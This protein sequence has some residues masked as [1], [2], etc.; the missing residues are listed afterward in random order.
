MDRIVATF[1]LIGV[2]CF[3][4]LALTQERPTVQNRFSEKAGAFSAH[5]TGITHIR[6]DFYN[7]FGFGLDLD[8]YFGESF[9]VELRGLL[10]KSSLSS[11]ALDLKERTGLTP[12]TYPQKG[13]VLAGGRYSIGYGKI[14]LFENIVMHFDPQVF[15]HGGVAFAER[16]I[17]PSALYG[18]SLLNHFRWGIQLKIDIA[19]SVQFE[20]RSN[21]GQVVSFGFMPSIGIGWNMGLLWSGEESR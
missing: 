6:N 21:R 18:L 19:G 1:T 14:L 3:S 20:E 10:I 17:I 2:L 8:Y 7:A 4:S 13:M 15:V 5:L 9:G 12:D 11:P 16:R